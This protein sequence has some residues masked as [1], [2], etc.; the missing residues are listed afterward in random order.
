MSTWPKIG[1]MSGMAKG[2]QKIL[3]GLHL[4]S[5]LFFHQEKSF[6]DLRLIS[7]TG[8]PDA[9]RVAHGAGGKR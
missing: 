3:E 5:V 2:S 6:Q 1:E 8:T 9:T 4:Y 7:V